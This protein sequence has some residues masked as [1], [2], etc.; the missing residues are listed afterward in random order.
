MPLLSAKP[1]RTVNATVTLDSDVA[2]LVDHYVAYCGEPNGV[3][4]KIIEGLIRELPKFDKEFAKY[5]EQ[6]AGET[7]NASLRV[8]QKTSAEPEDALPVSIRRTKRATEVAAD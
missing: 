8:K 1:T 7:A 3:A 4:D 5:M 2:A 6:H